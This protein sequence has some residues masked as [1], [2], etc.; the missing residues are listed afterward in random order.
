M[1]NKKGQFVKGHKSTCGF[2]K[3]SAGF[4]GKHSA[5]AKERMSA[6]KRGKAPWNKGL[7]KLEHPCLSRSGVKV[8]NIPWN[9]GKPHTAITGERNHRWKGGAN[10]KN[11][12]LRHSLEYRA[13]R[14]AVLGRDGQAC[15]WCGDGRKGNLDVDHVKSFADFPELR[16]AVDNGR[17][18]CRPCHR[19]TDNYLWKANRM[20]HGN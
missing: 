11:K 17:T 20:K 13:W 18:L 4:T 16:F 15:V 3:G 14:R 1:R 6:A 19:T 8:G 10:S 7:S 5:A 9:K 2:Q 12:K